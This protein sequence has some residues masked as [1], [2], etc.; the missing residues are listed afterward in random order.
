[1]EPLKENVRKRS[2]ERYKIDILY[3]DVRPDIDVWKRNVGNDKE[4]STKYRIG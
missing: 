3:G 4:K 1:V 2:E